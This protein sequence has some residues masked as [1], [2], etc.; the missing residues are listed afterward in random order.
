MKKQEFLTSYILMNSHHLYVVL[1]L[2]Y[3]LFIENIEL[4]QLSLVKTLDNLV[5]KKVLNLDKQ[6]L[7]TVRQRLFSVIILLKIMNGGKKN[8]VKNVNGN[9]NIHI[10]LMVELLRVVIQNMMNKEI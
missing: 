2:I 6:F 8:L 10:I 3:S 5:E 1:Q 9:S 7:V 4:V